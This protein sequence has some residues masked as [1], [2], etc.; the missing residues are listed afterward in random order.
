MLPLQ[1]V[2]IAIP[3]H[4][5]LGCEEGGFK[6]PLCL[7]L[8]SLCAGFGFPLL[9]TTPQLHVDVVQLD[10]DLSALSELDP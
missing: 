9:V 10:M 6:L 8:S 7:R 2:V 3:I 4:R 1:I 5:K